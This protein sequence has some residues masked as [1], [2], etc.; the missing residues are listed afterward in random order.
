MNAVLKDFSVARPKPR[1]AP[2]ANQRHDHVHCIAAALATASSL[3][4]ARGARLTKLRRRVLEHVWNSH[5]PVG[6]YELLNRLRADGR[7]AAPPTI[8]RALAFLADEGLIHRIETRNA[9]IG[10]DF[11]DRPHQAQYFICEQCGVAAEVDA[12]D[13][14][15]RIAARADELGFVVSGHNVEVLGICCLCQQRRVHVGSRA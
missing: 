1:T 12:S 8:Y 2:R 15:R 7:R 11:A 13:I 14:H 3:C 4:A 5:V 9:Y 6:A 10:C